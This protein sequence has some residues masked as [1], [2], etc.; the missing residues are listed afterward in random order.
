MNMTVLLGAWLILLIAFTVVSVVK[1]Q[2]SRREDDHLHIDETEASLVSMQVAI[3]HK[4]DVLDR[5]KTILLV[6]IVLTGLGIVALH[7][8]HVWQTGATV[9]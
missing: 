5:W 6:L 9:M 3:A 1:W 2:F 8:W 7:A 4:L